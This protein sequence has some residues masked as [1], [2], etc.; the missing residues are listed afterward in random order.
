MRRSIVICLLSC[1]I[2]LAVPL[3][4]LGAGMQVN[5]PGEVKRG[6]TFTLELKI[7]DTVCIKAGGV[8]L[9]YNKNMLKLVD[10]RWNVENP[11]MQSYDKEKDAGAFAYGTPVELTGLIFVATFQVREDAPYGDAGMLTM[12]KFI[13]SNAP[14]NDVTYDNVPS[15]IYVSCTAHSVED[16]VCTVCGKPQQSAS[17]T[18]A[19]QEASEAT[20]VSVAPQENEDISVDIAAPEETKPEKEQTGTESAREE[21]PVLT[22]GAADPQEPESFPWIYLAAGSALLVTVV[23]FLALRRKGRG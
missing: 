11:L 21:E 10:Y 3:Q 5:Q 17:Q 22:I 19:Q 23:I 6:E 18:P 4:A 9:T 16:G 1:L 12:L 15:E 14:E 13:N 7:S 8:R 2:I 20:A